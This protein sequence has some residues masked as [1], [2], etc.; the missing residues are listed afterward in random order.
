M[1]KT[2]YV[3]TSILTTM[4]FSGVLFGQT[5]SERKEITKVYNKEAMNTLAKELQTKETSAKSAAVSYAKSKNIPV[6]INLKDGGFAELQKIDKDGTPIYYRT[7]NV[8]AAKSTR[9]NFLNSGGNLGLELDGQGMIGYVWDG[10][11]ARVTHLEYDGSGGSNRVSV[12]DASSE[13]G[14]RLNFHAAHV[15]GTVCASGV[16]AAAKGMAPKAKVRGYMWNNDV[17]EAT[18]AASEGMLLSNHSYGFR[19][20]GVPDYYFGAYIEDSRD[21]DRVMYNAPNYLMVVA[22]GND[23]SSNYNASPLN[24]SFP[25]FDKLTGHSV[26]KNNLVV[27]NAQD[28]TIDAAGNLVGVVINSSSSQGPTDD[29]RIKP[30]IAGN[31]TGVYSTYQNSDTAYSSISGTS[32][33]SPNVMGSLLLLQQHH[34]NLKGSFMRSATLRG[35]ALHT[36]DDAGAVGPDAVFGWGLLNAKK[37]AE[38]LSKAGTS[39]IVNELNLKPGETYTINV[40]SDGINKLYASICWT[41]PAA[42]AVSTLNSNTARLVNDLDIRITKAG[43]PFLPWR[44]TGVN[45]NGKGD[46][47]R[48]NFERVDVDNASGQYTITITHKGTSLTGGSQNYSLI[49]TGVTTNNIVCNA[50]IPS[51]VVSSS[52]SQTGA[53]VSWNTVAGA[54]YEYRYKT[55]AATTWTTATAVTTTATLSGLTASTTY[56][57]QVKSI[58]SN[59]SSSEYSNVVSFTTLSNQVTPVNYCVSGSSNTDDERIARVQI[60]TINNI[61]TTGGGY[62]NYTSISTNVRKGVSNTIT[63][64]PVWRDVIY[65]EA[66]SVWVDYNSDGDFTDA[67]EQVWTRSAT[68]A[69]TVSGVF[70]VPNSVSNGPK[71]M[72]VSM[73]YNGIPTSCEIFTYGQT[74]DYTL[75]VTSG[76]GSLVG[77]RASNDLAEFNLYPSPAK[78]ILTVGGVSG[79]SSFFQIFDL[80]GQL[81]KSGNMI[82]NTVNVSDLSS[83]IYIFEALDGEQKHVKKFVKE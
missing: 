3:G 5:S 10:G 27:A 18:K 46:N 37:A 6:T 26:S 45:T 68:K 9:T 66:Y 14:V 54:S 56:Q 50:T 79:D 42:A 81:L 53:T 77:L 34:K 70:T 47:T 60:G 65:S 28:A 39:S 51:N 44:L 40:N 48:D 58:C 63:I 55:N 19:S 31:G 59:S 76:D 72:R 82:Q 52:I 20:D 62:E 73:K 36:A 35:L 17:S 41:D 33:A 32:M 67:G 30:D 11:H 1:K 38:T 13:G 7:Y 64:T 15:T 29:L 69:S 21:W 74:E 24:P 4:L 25:K 16:T 75:N 43:S 8:A 83:G 22:A 80:K 23:G 71:R 49:V 61:T 57:F 12:E 2:Y 78:D